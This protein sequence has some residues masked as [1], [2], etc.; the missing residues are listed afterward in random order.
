MGS[1]LTTLRQ[2]PSE[3]P[4]LAHLKE[5]LLPFFAAIKSS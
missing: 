1:F 3:A 2:D 4:P 5:K